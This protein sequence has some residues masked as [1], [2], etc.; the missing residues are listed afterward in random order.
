MKE[1]SLLLVKNA[2]GG[3]HWVAVDLQRRPLLQVHLGQTGLCVHRESGKS[4]CEEIVGI[5]KSKILD[6]VRGDVKQ[7]DFKK[8]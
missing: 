6:G 3:A 8:V 4:C 7:K 2:E 1:E 5:Q